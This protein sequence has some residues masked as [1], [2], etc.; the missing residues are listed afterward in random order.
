MRA[1]GGGRPGSPRH[2]P[3][4]YIDPVSVSGL[5]VAIATLARTVYT[6]LRKRTSWPPPAVVDRQICME[7]REGKT[8]D[9]GAVSIVTEITRAAL[10]ADWK[11]ELASD[12]PSDYALRPP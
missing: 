7:L 10:S 8:T 5:I 11:D 9:G 4:Q 3:A 1:R 2:R 12:P 6:D